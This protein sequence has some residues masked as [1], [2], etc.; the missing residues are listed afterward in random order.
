MRSIR[1]F[2]STVPLH[3]FVV[4]TVLIGLGLVLEYVPHRAPAVTASDRFDFLPDP[5]AVPDPVVASVEAPPPVPHAVDVV[6]ELRELGR[7]ALKTSSP[8]DDLIPAAGTCVRP[9]EREKKALGGRVASWID[10]SFPA[11]IAD[12]ADVLSISFGCKDRDGLVVAAHAD[13]ATKQKSTLSR[14]FIL[15]IGAQLDSLVEI[16]SSSTDTWM[17]WSQE[18][19]LDALALADLDGDGARDLVYSM[20]DHEGGATGSSWNVSALVAKRA[21]AVVAFSGLLDVEIADGA[22]VLA[23]G[24]DFDQRIYRCI[25]K[26]LQLASCAAVDTV[27]H[28]AHLFELAQ[29]YAGITGA[30]LV[31]LEQLVA[32]LAELGVG[33]ADR[34]RL[35]TDVRLPTATERA[36]RHVTAFVAKLD[37]DAD[38]A[39]LQGKPHGLAENYFADLRG[40]LGDTACPAA[41]LSAADTARIDGWLAKHV[42]REAQAISMVPACGAYAWVGW[43]EMVAGIHHDVLLALDSE[44]SRV[45]AVDSTADGDPTGTPVPQHQDVFF[46]HGTT[47]VGAVQ[48]DGRLDVVANGKV[49]GH[50]RGTHERYAFDPRWTDASDDLVVDPTAR[51]W[52]HPTPTGLERIDPEPLRA[53][54]DQRAALELVRSTPVTGAPAFVRALARLGANPT[55]LR[56]VHALG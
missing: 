9:T 17:E 18:R 26:D 5:E 34:E 7:A 52:F 11:E 39:T 23:L 3:L 28:R 40:Q 55:L 47:V 24:G 44:L 38:L 2:R 35:A 22:P 49:V 50:R 41:T 12:A 19:R 13:R 42:S 32:D 25:D 56:E 54:E 43:D 15:R 21:T 37:A 8:Q 33:K 20:T 29:Q 4:P 51:A 36:Q 53:H 31:D 46:R 16:Q 27:R 14:W 6:P 45:L 1:M 30:D 48:H 10:E